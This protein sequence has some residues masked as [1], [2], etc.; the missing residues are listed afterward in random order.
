MADYRGVGDRGLKG[1]VSAVA[2]AGAVAGAAALTGL[3]GPPLRVDT[4]VV[5]L[6]LATLCAEA[7]PALIVRRGANEEFD[8]SHAFTLAALLLAGPAAA[9]AIQLVSRVC[10]EVRERRTPIKGVF[11][12]AQKLLTL[13]AA[14]AAAL[15]AGWRPGLFEDGLTV[16]ALA[17][18]AAAALTFIA[19]N[20]LLV[21]VVCALAAG[22]PVVAFVRRELL[23]VGTDELLVALLAPVAVA[24]AIVDPLLI[25]LL[26]LPAWA[27]RRSGRAAAASH[28]RAR[29]DT[30]T[31]LPNRL[32]L[33]EHLEPYFASAAKG[34]GPLSLVAAGLDRFK[35]IN[36]TLGHE[37]GDRLLAAAARRL[38]E[39]AG[40]AAIAGRLQGDEF[41]IVVHDEVS[42][43]MEIASELLAA[44]E[45]PL[46]VDGISL[47]VGLS[48]G[49]ATAAE[50]VESLDELLRRADVATHAGKDNGVGFALYQP[51]RDNFSRRRLALTGD[52]RRAI[53]DGTVR[54]YF[55]PQLDL[56]TGAVVGAE[57]L[58]RWRREDGSFTSPMDFIPA[59]ERSGAIKPLTLHVLACALEAQRTWAA[60]GTCV[61]VAINLSARSLIAPELLAEVER[62][63]ERAGVAPA[64]LEL[65]V[66]ESMIMADPDR[67]RR[68]LERLGDLGIHLAIDDFGTGYSSL[69]YLSRLPVHTV[70]ID[71]SFV[72]D[73]ESD[74]AAE[75]IVRATIDLGHNLGLTVAGEGIE[76]EATRIRLRD[77]GCDTAQGFLWSPAVPAEDFLA[78]AAAAAPAVASPAS[79]LQA[80][81]SI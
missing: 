60:A 67:A 25:V 32:W 51:D 48:A 45:A 57:A 29:H 37:Q 72:K 26:A 39:H 74:P 27:L 5:V 46:D 19:V 38:A 71:R 66:T 42:R 1:F 52:L 8:V 21:C 16:E 70:K 47:E 69:A 35:E 14:G 63:L 3:I 7:F 36:E 30:L 2:L 31:G 23:R 80:T 78:V 55:Q 50:D 77:L 11:N 10:V 53:A 73:L 18:F 12:V 28:F 76:D 33:R 34:R 15:A 68:T 24:L 9:V 64:D 20:G 43:A 54:P 58:V 65:E 44:F 62:G 61:R 4:A 13:A 81:L 22:E 40:D 75:L 49:V 17:V 41:L 6:G 56:R 59:A 79:P